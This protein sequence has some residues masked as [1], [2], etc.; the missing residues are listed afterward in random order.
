MKYID[1]YQASYCLYGKWST[2]KEYPSKAELMRKELWAIINDNDPAF[3]QI[4]IKRNTSAI[5]EPTDTQQ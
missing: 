3:L 4:T 2:T 1:K 5:A